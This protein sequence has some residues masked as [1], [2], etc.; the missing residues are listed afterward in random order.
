MVKAFSSLTWDNKLVILENIAKR[1]CYRLPTITCLLCPETT[2]SG[3][4]LFIRCL[5]TTHIQETL[6]RVWV[7]LTFPVPSQTYKDPRGHI[8]KDRLKTLG[9]LCPEL[10]FGKFAWTK[11]AH[12]LFMLYVFF[13]TNCQNY[14]HVSSLNICSLNLKRQK[15]EESA[16]TV[17]RSL[18]YVEPSGGDPSSS[19]VTLAGTS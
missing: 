11:Q 1:G 7:C 17:K 18:E 2:K 9:I 15:M 5:F 16:T 10:L 6:I 14:L 13:L 8:W 12:F 19:R 3:N 4:H